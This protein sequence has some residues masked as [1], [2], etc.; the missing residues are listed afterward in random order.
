MMSGSD[1]LQRSG[2]ARILIV[3][4]EGIVARDLQTSL[5]ALGHVVCGTSAT[6]PDAVRQAR[7]ERPDVVLMD[8]R[9]RGEMDGIEAA[10]RIRQE[11][12]VPVVF[13]TAYA[14]QDTLERAADVGPYGYVLKPFEEQEL[15]VTVLMALWRHH[16]RDAEDAAL[17]ARAAEGALRARDEFLA[18]MAHELRTPVTA[19]QL[20][21]E[22]LRELVAARTGQADAGVLERADGARRS[23]GRLVDLVEAVLDVS[24]ITVG[25]LVLHREPLDLVEVVR[26]VAD[27]HK[28]LAHRAGCEL[29]VLAHQPVCGHFDRKRI[30]QAVAKLLSNAVK[31][32]Q[33]HPVQVWV[34]ARG[35]Q[36][37]LAVRDRGEGMAP[38]D[39]Q[40]VLGRY[41]RATSH[42]RH[43]GLG[44]GLYVVG[45]IIEAHGGHV[46]VDTRPGS[47][48]TFTVTLPLQ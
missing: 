32:G 4:D 46:Q 40:R 22:A 43:G 39:V 8:I 36:A 17:R 7:T 37:W 18:I 33:G 19:L 24:R 38:A 42:R 21:L 2:C 16:A 31:F 34:D 6:G 9:L 29:Q 35:G 12:D 25:G 44:L 28:W 41:E 45:Q 27:R 1:E 14:D 47:G 20:Q 11:R 10:R 5:E 15:H 3:E 48:A 13:L 30:E 23:V 26:A